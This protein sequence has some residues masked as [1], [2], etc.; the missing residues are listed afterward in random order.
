MNKTNL[1]PNEEHVNKKEVYKKINA[2][3]N[4]AVAK[5]LSQSVSNDIVMMRNSK[6]FSTYV[7]NKIFCK[8]EGYLEMNCSWLVK[9]LI[10]QLKL[11]IPHLTF[12][13][14]VI[15]A[16]KLEYIYKKV[17]NAKCELCG[18]DEEDVFHLMFECVHYKEFR[19]KYL[20]FLDASLYNR[21][22]YVRIFRDMS[23][24][25]VMNVFHYFYSIF[26]LRN[27][28]LEYMNDCE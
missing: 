9:Q 28:Y 25:E 6:F 23:D 3:I 10:M 13:G 18:K 14:K 12:K 11:G 2:E 22:N 15:R 17:E 27:V 26:K 8:R 7:S 16:K 24:D 20:V 19:N 1:E 4:K 21:N 5:M